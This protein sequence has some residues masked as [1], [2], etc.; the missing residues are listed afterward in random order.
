MTSYGLAETSNH[1]QSNLTTYAKDI[2]ASEMDFKV[3]WAKE[4]WKVLPATMI[5][6]QEKILNS[7]RSAIAK[8]VT[9]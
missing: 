7:R 1:I 5:G 9:F 6:R 3:D 8:T 4:H 2:R